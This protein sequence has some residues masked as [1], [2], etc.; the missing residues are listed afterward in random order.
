MNHCFGTKSTDKAGKH[1]TNEKRGTASYPHKIFSV[2]D[3]L[4]RSNDISAL[5]CCCLTKHEKSPHEVKAG[6]RVGVRFTF[7]FKIITSVVIKSTL[8]HNPAGKSSQ[9]LLWTVG[10][11]S[12]RRALEE[13]EWNLERSCSDLLGCSSPTLPP[14]HCF[15]PVPNVAP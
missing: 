6:L 2:Q 11:I 4:N 12:N 7:E 14:C 13:L 8:Y 10:L 15:S 3:A 9:D 1:T 5:I